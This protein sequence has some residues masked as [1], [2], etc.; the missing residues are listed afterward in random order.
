M[1]I[2]NF[3]LPIIA[4]WFFTAS[5]FAAEGPAGVLFVGVRD[6][7]S[8]I[9]LWTP[10]ETRPLTRTPAKEGNACWWPRKELILAS[11]EL[12]PDRYG[13]VAINSQ[14]KTIWVCDDPVGSLGWP[15]PSPWDDRILCVRAGADGLVHPGVVTFP[16]GDFMPF[17]FSDMSGGQLAWLTPDKIQLSRVTA[18]GFVITH[19]YLVSGEEKIILSGGNN[20]QSVVGHPGGQ[21]VMFVR[22]VGQ[23]GSIFRLWQNQDQSW[24]YE[25][26]T[27]ARTYDW[28]PALSPDSSTL[29]YR[30]LRQGFFVTVIRDFTNP[31]LPEKILP[32]E[33]FAQIYFPTILDAQT[34]ASLLA[35]ELE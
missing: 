29:I 35:A 18:E 10:Q 32:I 13:L 3:A 9:Y 1:K 2:R 6:G 30:S 33:G 34:T 4:A 20:W 17:T 8:D 11:R 31:S 22:R 14:L 16:E 5:I 19:R 12:E 7:A 27:N 28:Q 26:F 25:D 21:P 24:E 15:V 23:V